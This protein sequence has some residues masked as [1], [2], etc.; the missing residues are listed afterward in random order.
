MKVINAKGIYRDADTQQ[1]HCEH[2]VP[3]YDDCQFCEGDMAHG[4]GELAEET[5]FLTWTNLLLI[6]AVLGFAVGIG[7][8][9]WAGA[10]T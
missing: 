1:L 2:Q 3:L 10:P 4:D 6:V 7:L 9:L 5:N 8:F